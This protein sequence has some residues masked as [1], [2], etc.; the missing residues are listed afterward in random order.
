MLEYSRRAEADW[1]HVRLLPSETL[2]DVQP[3]AL[4]CR[5]LSVSAVAS[6]YRE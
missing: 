1:L 2:L 6:A 5:P 3:T 4:A